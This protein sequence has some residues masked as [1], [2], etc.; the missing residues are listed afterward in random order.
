[1]GLVVQLEVGAAHNTP[2]VLLVAQPY[3]YRIAPYVSA[4]TQL[5]INVIIASQSE[6]SLVSEVKQ[7][8]NVD[9]SNLNPPCLWVFMDAQCT[10]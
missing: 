5:G 6:N 8:I 9:L 3:S 10:C 1:M 2:S 7:G 4:A